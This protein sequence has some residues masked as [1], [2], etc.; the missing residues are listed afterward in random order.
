M[1]IRVAKSDVSLYPPLMSGCSVDECAYAFHTNKNATEVIPTDAH[2]K[3]DI[4]G[5]QLNQAA[6][7][8]GA[9]NR[10]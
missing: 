8:D 6:F 1:I 4:F 2:M 5:T 3:I 9:E 7:A 10:E